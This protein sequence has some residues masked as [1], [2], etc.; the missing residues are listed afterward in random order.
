MADG[1]RLV[2]KCPRCGGELR[3]ADDADAAADAA[4]TAA[5]AAPVPAEPPHLVLGI[6]H[7]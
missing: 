6:P 4:A 5:E 3:F 1:L 7:R 2:G